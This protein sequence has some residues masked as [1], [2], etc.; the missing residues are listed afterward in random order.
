[1]PLKVS[2]LVQDLKL[3]G[4]GGRI[5][6]NLQESVPVQKELNNVPGF[7]CS[8]NS[9]WHISVLWEFTWTLKEEYSQAN[10]MENIS[11]EISVHERIYSNQVSDS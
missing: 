8:K 5:N 7:L 11:L 1:M 3:V 2:L 9:T 6:I 10:N 4:D